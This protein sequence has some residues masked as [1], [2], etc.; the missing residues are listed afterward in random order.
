MELRESNSDSP[1][2][3][4]GGG[5]HEQHDNEANAE[6]NGANAVLRLRERPSERIP[7]ILEVLGAVWTENSNQRLT[8]LLYNVLAEAN[9]ADDCYQIE[10]DFLLEALRQYDRDANY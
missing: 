6:D 10:D 1:Q 5:S 7:E 8:Q 4:S 9:V 3:M 2:N